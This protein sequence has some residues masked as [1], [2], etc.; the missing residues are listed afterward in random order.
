MPVGGAR[1]RT[2][3]DSH[4]RTAAVSMVKYNQYIDSGVYFVIA[5]P[6]GVLVKLYY[7]KTS[8]SILFSVQS[9]LLYC[10]RGNAYNISGVTNNPLQALRRLDRHDFQGA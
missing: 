1:V 10:L 6:Y 3:V 8:L 7:I 5:L 9:T 4:F 2:T